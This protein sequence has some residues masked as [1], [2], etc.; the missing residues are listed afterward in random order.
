MKAANLSS[1][2]VA[3]RHLQKLELGYLQKNEY[4]EYTA[5]NKAHMAGY[6]WVGHRLMPKM[7][8]HS[9]VFTSALLAELIVLIRHLPYENYEFKAFFPPN[10]YHRC[11]I[12]CFYS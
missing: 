7:W 5:K 6:M 8:S 1:P 3:Y 9:L 12:G 2:S 4:G 11:C 10:A